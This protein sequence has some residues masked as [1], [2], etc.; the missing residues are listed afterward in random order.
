MKINAVV[1]ILKI[2]INYRCM[3]FVSYKVLRFKWEFFTRIVIIDK[4]VTHIKRDGSTKKLTSEFKSE[5]L[6]RDKFQVRIININY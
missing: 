4:N 3:K 5:Y 2:R 1:N 6:I